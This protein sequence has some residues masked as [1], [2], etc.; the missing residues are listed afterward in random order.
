MV[1]L[2]RFLGAGW[3][4]ATSA[5]VAGCAL[6]AGIG[7]DHEAPAPGP[8]EAR[9][10]PPPDRVAARRARPAAS[11]PDI[12]SWYGPWHHGRPTASGETFDMDAFTAAHPSLPLGS[13]VE[14]L[15]VA[16]GRRVFVR[17]NDRGPYIAGRTIDLSY[18]AA[19]ALGMV[20][21]GVAR[22]RIRKAK[23]EVCEPAD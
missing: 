3:M 23:R 15:H 14:V 6:V 2:R 13:C 5:L 12:A 22:V 18:R 11:R 16:S 19:Q 10:V 8:V 20:D 4:V 21:T 7:A 9:F 17:V 1:H